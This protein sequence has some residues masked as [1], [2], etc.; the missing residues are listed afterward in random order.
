MSS[1]TVIAHAERGD[2]FM[3]VI[4]YYEHG[5]FTATFQE[6]AYR[7]DTGRTVLLRSEPFTTEIGALMEW[8]RTLR[9]EVN[10]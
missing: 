10:S 3:Q 9:E 8:K 7:L 4:T 1:P 5:V 2:H 6:Y